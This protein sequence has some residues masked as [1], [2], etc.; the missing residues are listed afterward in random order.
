MFSC[1]STTSESATRDATNSDATM[2]DR[3][4][5]R[6]GR[7]RNDG[8]PNHHGIRR[9]GRP[10]RLLLTDLMQTALLLLR[11]LLCSEQ[12]LFLNSSRNVMISV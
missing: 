6:D 3:I 8:S 7:R 4:R 9:R 12:F 2:D 11:L 10:V 5:T 1:S